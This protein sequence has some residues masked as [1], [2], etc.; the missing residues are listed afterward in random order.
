MSATTTAVTF[1]NKC[2]LHIWGHADEGTPSLVSPSSIALIWYLNSLPR[3]LRDDFEIVCSNNT[4]LSMT[5]ELPVL[6]INSPNGIVTRQRCGFIDIIRYID[7]QQ[8][9]HKK[10]SS[11]NQQ[12][13]LESALLTYTMTEL[14]LL[15]DYQ[16]YLNGKNY[17]NFTNK[18]F[19]KLLYWPMWYNTPLNNRALT[20]KRY[21]VHD[22]PHKILDTEMEGF[23]NIHIDEKH[24][25]DP[26]M[27]HSK[28]F[29]LTKYKKMQNKKTLQNLQDDMNY[30]KRFVE[31]LND[32]F[33]VAKDVPS[34]YDGEGSCSSPTYLLLL[35]NLYIQMELP[36]GSKIK[37]YLSSVEHWDKISND[38]E[39]LKT[40][41]YG[42]M[43]IQKDGSIDRNGG[44]QL[45]PA[46]F[47]EQGNIITSLY[48]YITWYL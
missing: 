30:N 2:V 5:K 6:F 32:W 28:T 16:L 21:Y 7:T 12:N 14:T 43:I 35:A 3:E 31:V 38:L 20:R 22:S 33:E 10:T 36:N 24:E 11:S 29:K 15:T 9:G 26:S 47:N 13:L 40:S 37:E 27:A 45:Q 48:N 42:E 39:Y 4:D 17:S 18:V 46:K 25:H 41:G 23:E 44:L 1:A 34:I 8:Q 19:S